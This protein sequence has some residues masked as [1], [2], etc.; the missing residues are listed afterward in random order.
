MSTRLSRTVRRAGQRKT[1][2]ALSIIA[3]SY[4]P[5]IQQV[6]N[7]LSW[8]EGHSVKVVPYLKIAWA[9]VLSPYFGPT[10]TLVALVVLFWRLWPNETS[11]RAEQFIAMLEERIALART[12]VRRS[13]VSFTDWKTWEEQTVIDIARFWGL[14]FG[15][16]CIRLF[17][18]SGD[19]TMHE[20][21]EGD[22]AHKKAIGRQ[23]RVLNELID[24]TDSGELRKEA[25]T[26][27]RSTSS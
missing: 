9:F 16:R 22:P 24:R 15:W 8:L 5:Q 20:Q 2:I 4:A 11:A 13:R 18:A 14:D 17:R 23:I 25:Q 3:F 12:L 10:V 26:A 7:W 27:L 19:L 1:I 6:F 21:E